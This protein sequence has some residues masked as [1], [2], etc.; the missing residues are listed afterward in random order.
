MKRVKEKGITVVVYEPSLSH[1][2]TDTYE[3]EKI[4]TDLDIFKE[5]CDM[6]VANRLDR[7]LEDVKNKVYTRDLFRRD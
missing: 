1:T 2:D 5:I 7:E 6:I 4:I 3:G